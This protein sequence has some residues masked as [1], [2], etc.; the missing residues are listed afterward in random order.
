MKKIFAQPEI[1]VVKLRKN[2]NIVT[3][4]PIPMGDP[5]DAGNAE[6]PGMRNFEWYGE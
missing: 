6:A 3:T 2:D 4:S 5:G 1:M